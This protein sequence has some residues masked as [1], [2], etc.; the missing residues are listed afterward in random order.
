V[1]F[2]Q[3]IETMGLLPPPDRPNEPVRRQGATTN[4]HEQH[5]GRS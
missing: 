2:V 1:L 4:D 3:Y 5:T